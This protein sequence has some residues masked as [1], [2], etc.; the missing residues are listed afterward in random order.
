TRSVDVVLPPSGSAQAERLVEQLVAEL[1]SDAGEPAVAFRNGR[2]WV[3][4]FEA[5]RLEDGAGSAMPLR[6]GGV[7][8]IT[9]G[10]GGMGLSF[11]EEL[12][13]KVKARLV[14]TGRSA[15]PPREEWDSHPALRRL[16]ALGAQVLV[17]SA[18]VTD[19]E[20]MRD[21]IAEA[22]GHFGA[23]HGVIHA[24]GVPGGGMLQLRTREA[25]EAVLAPK[26]KGTQVLAAALEG[27][28]LDF[29]VACSSLTSVVGRFGQMD[30]TAANTF[31]DA[32]MRAWQARTGTYAVS[33]NWGAWDEVGMAARPATR[34]QEGKPF[35]HPLL[36]QC[37]VDT[38]QRLVFSGTLGEARSLWMTDEHRI[39][40]NPTV[41]GVAY[42]ELVR[43]AIAGRAQGR[44]IELLDTYF[45]TPLRVPE[46]ETRELRLILEQ[47]GDGYRWVARS[48][49]K[50]GTGPSTDH[51]AGH[52]RIGGPR[53]PR[54]MD[55][56]ELR[57]RCNRPQ[58]A[59]FETEHEEG[60][61]PRW[62]SVQG[63][64]PGDG[65]LLVT[66]ELMPEFA[67]DFERMHFHPS[68][69]D[70]TSGIAK[71][72]LSEHGYYLPFCYKQLRLYADVPRRVV[73]Y[74]RFR[75]DEL[76]DG[77]T[78]AFDVVMMDE[79]GRVL[80]EVERLTQKR[81]N[82]PAAELRALAAA[83]RE[84]AKARA[85]P[86]EETQEILPREGVLALERILAARI[87]P[88]VVVSVRDLQA[89]L[90]H[91]DEQVREHFLQ[92]M[93]ETRASGEKTAR[94]PLKTP[95]V[96]PRNEL[97]QRIAEAWQGVLGID[98][99][100]IH[101]NFLELGGDSVQAI[102][103]IARG[104]HLGLQLNPQQF[105]QYSTIAELAGMLS[106][107][108]SKQAEQGAVTGPAPLTPGQRHVL[109]QAPREPARA[110]RAVTLEVDGSVDGATVT[111]ALGKVLAHH[112]A[113]RL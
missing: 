22:R 78:L 82:D 112:D 28:P 13:S 43:A 110:S 21:V 113:L 6:E 10:L 29:F 11:A 81:V 101:D 19:A 7:Y 8:L 47:D 87:M 39:L 3:Q 52:V 24:A 95:Y 99:V 59:S 91:T 85:L 74:A 9:G 20:R 84:S 23:L 12:A 63:I 34:A 58:P 51:A 89:T 69:I 41:P 80:A 73:S 102:Q 94:P 60:L 45:L 42:L 49:P 62:R 108:L 77:E 90:E 93:G 68:L 30:Y 17:L 86:T 4:D 98:K 25:I 40:G 36:H 5:L 66:L 53:E 44:V 37:L 92:A 70:R 50:G 46:K 88:Q 16:E 111:R 83:A 106:S 75:E 48:L 56:E 61:G 18:D 105:F 97:E 27:L 33:V 104:N 54:F 109:E 64:H 76:T 55:L 32:F 38:P 14:L 100:G 2:R 35:D 1:D 67:P 103:I 31:Q 72:F 15:V 71:S 96:A 107:M 65:E 26:V 57:R 79:H